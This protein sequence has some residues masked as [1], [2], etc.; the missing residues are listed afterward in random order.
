[1]VVIWWKIVMVSSLYITEIAINAD[2]DVIYC[3]LR[4]NN[5]GS[6]PICWKIFN[7]AQ[8]ILVFFNYLELLLYFIFSAK[9]YKHNNKKKKKSIFYIC[10]CSIRVFFFSSLSLKI[11]SKETFR[12][13]C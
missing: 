4:N 7:F 9:S 13:G 8:V 5:S 2:G 6:S 1:M 12:L 11:V 10:N 3:N